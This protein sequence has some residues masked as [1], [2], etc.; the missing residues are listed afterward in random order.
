[1]KTINKTNRTKS[2]LK[3]TV[4]ASLMV[5][6]SIVSGNQSTLTNSV[7]STSYKYADESGEKDKTGKEARKSIENECF[8]STEYN[9]EFVLEE[10]IY[11]ED[12]MLDVEDE[13]WTKSYDEMNEEQETEL[14]DWMIDLSEWRINEKKIEK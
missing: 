10:E 6:W 9:Y 8:I 13:F 7:L 4:L 14:E 11:L 5:S 3:Y 2:I 12:W 1:M